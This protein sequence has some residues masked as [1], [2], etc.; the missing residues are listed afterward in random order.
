MGVFWLSLGFIF[1]LP[2]GVAAG[3]A[4]PGADPS[5]GFNTPGFNGDLAL[6]LIAWGLA[7]F[8]VLVCSIKTNIT[9]II[10]FTILDAG[11][12]LFAASH[13]QTAAENF[14][15]GNILAKVCPLE[16]ID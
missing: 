14:D 10:L 11:L 9:F 6:F 7:I 5:T 13:F 2:S 12:F 8:V 15:I 4:A 1:Y 16:Y 3:Y